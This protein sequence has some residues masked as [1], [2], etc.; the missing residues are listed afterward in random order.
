MY[1]PLATKYRP[2][3]FSD[4]VGQDIVV[5][6]LM[7]GLQK[8]R[9]GS[10]L[11][12]AGTRGVGKTTLARIL[13]KAWC[14]NNRQ[15]GEPCC[16]CESCV[17][18]ARGGQIDVL[19]IDAA[20]NTGVDDVREII[21][22]SRYLPTSSKYKIFIIDETHMLSKSAFNA[23]L[24]TLEEPPAH[25]KFLMAT[26]EPHKIPD[27]VLSRVLRFDLRSLDAELIAQHLSSIC[28]KERIPIPAESLALIA[29]SADGSVRDALSLLDQAANLVEN[30]SIQTK[31]LLDML[32]MSDDT[33]ILTLLKLLLAKNTQG[34]IQQY[35]KILN[36]ACTP[37]NILET[38]MNY[39]HILTCLQLNVEP[40][41]NMANEHIVRQLQ[42]EC[43]SVSAPALSRIWQLL[44]KGA[45]EIN[46]GERADVLLEMI[47]IRIIYATTL[48]DLRDILHNNAKNSPQNTLSKTEAQDLPI[49]SVSDSLL[50]K[51]HKMFPN[52]KVEE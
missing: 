27:T 33:E 44:V 10:A 11:L 23:L 43:S 35:R 46:I 42:D 36:D 8:D 49:N 48:P 29:D 21:E 37:A 34:A 39:I 17:E 5:K 13:A 2:Q 52:A 19:E 47:L 26:T 30:D 20:S 38:L 32:H 1:V 40:R 14:C 4:V 9:L 24:K 41:K 50:E 31:D 45:E 6:I 12:F 7:R 16:K 22:S 28:N 18:F 25:A 51:A 3:K 15:D